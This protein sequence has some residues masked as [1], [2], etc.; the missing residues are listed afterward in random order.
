MLGLSN[1]ASRIVQSTIRTMSV[2]CDRVGGINLAQGVCDTEVPEV[3]RHASEAAIEAGFNQYTRLDGI[4]RLRHAITRKLERQNG[5][6]ADP[7]TELLVTSGATGG[8]DAACRAL[9]NP[10]DEVILFEPYYGYHYATLVGQ[11]C[12]PVLVSLDPPSYEFV[13]DRLVA[14]I[15]PKTRGIMVN[16]P[17]NPSGK[18]FGR[19]ELQ[20]IVDVAR[21]HDLFIFTDEIYEHFVYDGAR[22]VS[23]ATLQGAAE[24]TI[25]I[26]GF[27]KTFSITGWRVG[28][29][30]ASAR[31]I[32]AISYFH[33]LTYVC[34]PSAF[35]HGVAAGL[36]ELPDSFYSGL[37]HDYQ[38]KRE[39]I[40]D[41]LRSA[42]LEPSIPAGSYYVLADAS[43]VTGANSV[44]KAMNLLRLTGVASVPGE[45]FFQEGRG[46]TLL[47]FCFAKTDVDL[48]KA[49]ERLARVRQ[50]ASA[51]R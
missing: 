44:E 12:R 13:L 30:H 47:R 9:L 51:S 35:Q 1:I 27:S 41:A 18:I 33:D 24:R 29:L 21:A 49:C 19:D 16:T 20:Q 2:E 10:G 32:P 22:H 14:A 46:D 42:G 25:M 28:Y 45:A 48:E 31:W 34:A 7:D 15:T 17:A 39:M 26:G 5:I 6:V 3:V 37:V 4:A 23:P 40:C 11:H 43:S 8:F 38:H 36:E 50:L